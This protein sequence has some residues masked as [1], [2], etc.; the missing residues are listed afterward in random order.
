[1]WN[2]RLGGPQS[3]CGQFEEQNILFPQLEIDPWVKLICCSN[4][5]VAAS[6]LT[7]MSII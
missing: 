4:Y 5:V 6:V 2:R 3:Q 1:M 7:V